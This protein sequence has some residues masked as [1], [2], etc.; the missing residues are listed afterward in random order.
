MVIGDVVAALVRQSGQESDT[1]SVVREAQDKLRRAVQIANLGS[2]PLGTVIEAQVAMLGAMQAMFAA[3]RVSTGSQTDGGV[4]TL[5]IIRA[6]DRLLARRQRAFQVKTVLIA[7]AAAGLIAGALVLWTRPG[8]SVCQD[9]RGG[10]FCG[11]W[12]IAPD[13]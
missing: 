7:I 1:S 6:A 4:T 3:A 12:V 11:Q 13:Q 8:A 5:E 2:D 9:V 10:R